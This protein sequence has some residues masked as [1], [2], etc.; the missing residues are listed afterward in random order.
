[1]LRHEG[2]GV[3]AVRYQH[4][5]RDSARGPASPGPRDSRSRGPLLT[6]ST[7]ERPG[8]G[9]TQA[10]PGG[11]PGKGGSRLRCARRYQRQLGAASLDGVTAA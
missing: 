5:G 4:L 1:M 3:A 8:A 11:C 10:F 2:R 7:V 6:T 9:C